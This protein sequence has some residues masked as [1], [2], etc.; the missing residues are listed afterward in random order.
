MAEKSIAYFKE[1]CIE[2]GV[3]DLHT[4]MVALGW[5][6]LG[7]FAFS[8]AYVPGTADE[9]PFVN[10]VVKRLG[11]DPEDPRVDGLRRLFFE[12]YTVA[13]SEMRRRAENELTA[14]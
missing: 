3:G 14:R 11:V 1:S 2:C 4:K 12:A 9:T 6:T 8:S 10:R 5:T 7:K 13:A